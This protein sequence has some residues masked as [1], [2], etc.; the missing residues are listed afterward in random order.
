MW[1][2]L[3]ILLDGMYTMDESFTAALGTAPITVDDSEYGIATNPNSRH[4]GKTIQKQRLL[5]PYSHDEMTRE[6][7]AQHGRLVSPG[8]THG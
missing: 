2:F 1:T 3:L 7:F 6:N 5:T 4:D 8:S